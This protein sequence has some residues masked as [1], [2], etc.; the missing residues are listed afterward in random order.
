M[1][2]QESDIDPVTKRAIQDNKNKTTSDNFTIQ[3]NE[4]KV[5]MSRFSRSVDINWALS[6]EGHINKSNYNQTIF[7]YENLNRNQ[8]SVID[9]NLIKDVF[10]QCESRFLKQTQY[11]FPE[12]EE[13]SEFQI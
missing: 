8:I 2:S 9:E 13:I 6:D 10:S 7:F 1:D 5:W 3:M 12:S 4:V 11:K